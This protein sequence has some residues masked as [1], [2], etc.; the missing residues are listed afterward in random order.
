[1]TDRL[2]KMLENNR[3]VCR[4][5]AKRADGVAFLLDENETLDVSV[6]WTDWLGSSTIASVTNEATGVSVTSANTATTATL[7]L[8][9]PP[10]IIEHRITT[11]GG[12]V[13]ELRI[14][15]NSP[16]GNVS[17]DYGLCR[18]GVVY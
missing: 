5:L 12:E 16:T 17:D 10:G 7:T 2:V 1:M 3:R 14:Y 13:K 6:D 9:A 18:T 4:G 11:D 15:V 8:S